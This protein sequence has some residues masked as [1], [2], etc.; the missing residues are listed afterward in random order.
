MSAIEITGISKFYGKTEVL[1][2]VNLS[3]RY[4]EIFGFLGPNGAGKSTTIR[5]IM[6]FIYPEKGLI[7]VDNELV[8][9]THYEYRNSIGYISAEG[10]LNDIWTGKQHVEFVN[11]TRNNCRDISPDVERLGLD[12]E[13]K[14]KEL[15]TGNKKKLSFILGLMPQP[16]ILI[17]DEPTAGLDPL[18]QE[19]IYEML[20]E[21]KKNGGCVF[22]SSH[23]LSEVE[24]I[25]DRIAIIRSGEIVANETMNSIREKSVHIAK[26]T[27]KAGG[28]IPDLSKFGVINSQTPDSVTMHI[29]GDINSFISAVSK[30]DLADLSFEHAGLEE[31]FINYYQGSK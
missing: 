13:K 26:V 16:K 23:N 10:Q 9:R 3:I 21:F 14:V 28:K 24:R 22:F 31:V 20:L 19:T 8:N 1:K 17:L 4:N 18:L 30:Y 29:E 25:C 12:L 27:V 11:A 15:S 2:D 6:G 7:K 5:C